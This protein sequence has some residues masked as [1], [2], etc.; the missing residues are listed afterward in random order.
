M[1]TKFAIEYEQNNI[2]AII[3]GATGG[4]K[5]MPDCSSDSETKTGW[6]FINLLSR[7]GHVY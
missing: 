4:W 1:A 7:F 6:T 3:A 5:C 2:P